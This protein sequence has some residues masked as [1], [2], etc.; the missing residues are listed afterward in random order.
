MDS[1]GKK[2]D[3]QSSL[4]LLATGGEDHDASGSEAISLRLEEEDALEIFHSKG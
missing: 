1:R 2:E 3:A 4:S